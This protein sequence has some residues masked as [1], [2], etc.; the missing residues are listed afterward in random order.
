[1]ILKMK[2]DAAWAKM[3]ATAEL[4]SD[5]YCK[6]DTLKVRANRRSTGLLTVAE[7][8]AAQDNWTDVF[9]LIRKR[10]V[11]RT[12]WTDVQTLEQAAEHLQV[13]LRE[14]PDQASTERD[15]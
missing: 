8:L 6:G 4:L 3:S 7:G 13:F 2:S 15:I 11:Y 5:Q 9:E 14:R 12:H 10:R 1:M